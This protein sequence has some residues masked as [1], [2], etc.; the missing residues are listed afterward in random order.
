MQ[1]KNTKAEYLLEDVTFDHEDAHL[2]YTLGSGAASMLNEAYV[3]KSDESLSEEDQVELEEL[4]KAATKTDGGEKL[5]A[6]AYAYVPDPEKPS[7]WKLRID[8]ANHTRAAVAALGKGFRGQKVQ[9]P[10]EDLPAVKR[11][12]RAA[13]KKF[14]PE[15][16]V[17]EVIKSLEE[18]KGDAL[19]VSKSTADEGA[20]L[21][22]NQVTDKTEI[23]KSELDEL[24]KMK[25]QLEAFKAKEAEEIVKSKEEIVKSATFIDNAD[26]VVEAIIKSEEGS[27]IESLIIKAVEAVEKAKADTKAELD[28]EIE[29]AKSDAEEAKKEADV[30][31]AE[32]AKP[33]AIEGDN[34]SLEDAEKDVK[35]S[36][37]LA[38]F[39]K[40]NY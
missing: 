3:L 32:F 26:E 9:I 2:A 23:S 10:E 37:A 13:Y 30:V 28:A 29:K 33:E 38:E 39:I 5:S 1:H 31:K 24:L 25:E 34:S 19:S 20:T 7:T 12:V 22:D 36:T 21:E 35:K 40:E 14:F 11:K 4:I 8:D 16:E 27:L 17:P 15:N 18:V 6:S